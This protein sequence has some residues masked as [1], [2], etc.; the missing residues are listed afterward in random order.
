MDWITGM[1]KA[2]DYIESNITEKLDY[3]NIAANAYVSSYHFQRA[4]SIMCGFTL[5]EY[6]RNRR[7]TLAANELILENNKVIDIALKYGYDS[8]DSFAKAFTRFHGIAPSLVRKTQGELKSFSRLSI[9]ILLEGGITMN[10]KIEQKSAFSL[11]GFKKHFIGDAAER[12]EQ[13]K[14]F[15]CNTR[16][17]QDVLLELRD[18]EENIWYDINTNFSDDGYDHYI[19][20]TSDKTPPQGYEKVDI[21]AATYVVCETE[22]VKY[23]TILHGDLRKQIVTEWLPSSGYQLSNSPE[24]SVTHWYKNPN[25]E[26]RY[27]EIWL[28]IEKI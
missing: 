2:I 10:Y 14:D 26:K 13:E 7:L 6:I 22:R 5:G 25:A 24:I 27:I 1:Q 15:W 17:E 21:P 9:R 19:A 23:P 18:T 20:I 3:D 4:F 12:F 28:P 11:V 16:N 8:P